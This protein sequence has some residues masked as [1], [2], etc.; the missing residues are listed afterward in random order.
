MMTE[1][2]VTGNMRFRYTG[3]WFELVFDDNLTMLYG[4]SGTGKT[5]L[6]SALKSHNVEI[7]KIRIF[8]YTDMLSV[9]EE[10]RNLSGKFIVADN[11]DV[12]GH[13]TA[14]IRTVTKTA[15]YVCHRKKKQKY[16]LTKQY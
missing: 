5:F 8:N 15:I 1:P 13:V 14:V 2:A 10:I 7:G 12:I 4:D 9:S 3:V 11:A 6:C 16:I